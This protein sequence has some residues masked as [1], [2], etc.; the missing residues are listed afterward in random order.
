MG[1]G[2]VGLATARAILAR[3]P[4]TTPP[5]VVVFE[6]EHALATHQTGRNSGVIHC[7]IYYKP[8]SLKAQLCVR[9]NAMTYEYLE[10]SKGQPG[11]GIPFERCGKLIVA[12][13]EAEVATLRDLL[14]R[15]RRNGV[16]GLTFLDTPERVREVEPHCAGLAAIRCETT[17]IVDWAQVARRF[18]DDVTRAGGAIHLNHEVASF[19]AAPPP[20]GHGDG[21]C[22]V[23]L[24]FA[25]PSVNAP[26]APRTPPPPQTFRHVLVCGGLHADRLAVQCGGSPDPAIVPFRGEYLVLKRDRRHLVR[27]NIYPVPDPR[28]PFL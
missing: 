19:R 2:I 24:T 12:V 23:S 10:A 15:G 4:K 6:K 16:R 1:G 27:G 9:G 18:A 28:V 3:L 25:D 7:G 5:R 11:G 8:G 20:P 17:G 21:P 26:G 13:T 22:S 14:E